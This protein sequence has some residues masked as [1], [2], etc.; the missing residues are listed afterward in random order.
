M[1]RRTE[2]TTTQK[3]VKITYNKLVRDKV[4]E[5][6]KASGKTAETRIL[7]DPEYESMLKAK[8]LEECKEYTEASGRDSQIEEMADIY[9]VLNTLAERKNITLEE[10]VAAAERKRE[11]RGGFSAKIMLQA[12]TEQSI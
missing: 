5:I 11:S 6:I 10:V 7:S 9:E 8:L 1:K 2:G 3:E 12:V 4:P